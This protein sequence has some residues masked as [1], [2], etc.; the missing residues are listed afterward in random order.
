MQKIRIKNKRKRIYSY[1]LLIGSI[2]LSLFLA[3]VFLRVINFEYN[4]LIIDVVNESDWRKFHAF[5][6]EAFIDDPI[7]L[8]RPKI[9]SENI[10]NKQGFRGEI[11]DD[12][13]SHYYKI[14]AVGDSNTLGPNTIDD[15]SWPHY[16][17]ELLRENNDETIVMNAGVWGYSAY[18]GLERFK[19]FLL[20]KPD[21]VLISFGSN[22]AALVFTPDKK[23]NKKSLAMFEFLNKFKLY[24]LIKGTIV[25]FGGKIL[26]QNIMISS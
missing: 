19:E 8:W 23:W 20:Y 3:E 11:V 4:P 9:D 1:I 24:S 10:F 21:M 16:L 2:I 15:I 26:L 5:K 14:L 17:E 22:D 25:H 12:T 18:Q 13:N 6:D 7:L